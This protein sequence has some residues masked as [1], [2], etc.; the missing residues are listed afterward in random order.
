[1]LS[2]PRQ[3]DQEERPQIGVTNHVV[4]PRLGTADRLETS[5]N[6][7]KLIQISSRE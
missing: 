5:G 2:A 3:D 1:M 7:D 4:N 6:S